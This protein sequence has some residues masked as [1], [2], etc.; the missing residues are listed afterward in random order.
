MLLT[1]PPSPPQ[2]HDWRSPNRPGPSSPVLTVSFSFFPF[3][4][5]PENLSLT[6]RD[7]RDAPNSIITVD[8]P[9]YAP[10]V[11]RDDRQNPF[12]KL[13]GIPENLID[14]PCLYLSILLKSPT[15]VPLAWR[16]A[17]VGGLVPLF[18][19]F[20]TSQRMVITFLIVFWALCLCTSPSPTFEFCLT[21]RPNCRLFFHA[22]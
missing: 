1:T 10:I 19:D 6:G 18:S 4:P 12:F 8:P 13:P 21:S 3:F 15:P 7:L 17:L 14:P 5:S 9:R 16:A 22:F 11:I 20:L 2:L